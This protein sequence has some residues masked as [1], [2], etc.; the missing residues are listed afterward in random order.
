MTGI[1]VIGGTGTIGRSLLDELRA[2]GASARVLVRDDEKARAV[3]EKGFEPVRGDLDE[4]AGLEAALAGADALFLLSGQHPRQAELQ[5][6]AV[7]AARRA[8][9]ASIVK[10][11]GGNAVTGERSPSFA[12]RA[13]AETERQ[14]RDSGLGWTFLRPS[15]FFQNM[16]N[17]AEPIRNG[18]LPMPFGD[19]RTAMVD[20][21]DVAAVAAAVLAGDSR[22]DGQA[23]S[24][25][26]PESLTVAEAAERLSRVLGREIVYPN[27]PVSAAVD[28]MRARGAPDWLQ[29]HVA[30]IMEIMRSGAAAETTSTVE[31]VLGRPPRS[32]EQFARDHASV[33]GGPS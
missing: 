13:H 30:E 12:G 24:L 16:L 18:V 15:Y 27:P 23:Y 2:A 7:E 9:V 21:R 14:I 19:A 20:T 31:D 10:L 29:Q 8:G 33:L 25:T 6:N 3:E 17:L 22:H 26:G 32:L 5:G 1:F 28:A 4:P 11:S